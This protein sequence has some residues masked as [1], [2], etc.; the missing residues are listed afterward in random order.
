VSHKTFRVVGMLFPRQAEVS[1]P[2]LA[3]YFYRGSWCCVAFGDLITDKGLDIAE[4]RAAGLL[5]E[6]VITPPETKYP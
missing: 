2:Q 4:M 1:R 3:Q 5:I 6:E